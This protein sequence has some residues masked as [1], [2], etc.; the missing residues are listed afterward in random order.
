MQRGNY[1]SAAI[2]IGAGELGLTL[3]TLRISTSPSP[4]SPPLLLL[5]LLIGSFSLF[6]LLLPPSAETVPDS[7]WGS[8]VAS[9]FSPVQ[10]GISQ[11]TPVKLLSLKPPF[12]HRRHGAPERSRARR[13]ALMAPWFALGPSLCDARAPGGVASRVPSSL[14]RGDSLAVSLLMGK[15]E[16]ERSRRNLQPLLLL[17]ARLAARLGRPV[18][19]GV[20]VAV[21]GGGGPLDAL[22]LG[23]GG[24]LALGG[25]RGRG[26]FAG[27]GAVASRGAVAGRGARGGVGCIAQVGIGRGR[28][29]LRGGRG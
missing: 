8:G 28:G 10:R 4:A 21:H 9:L 15:G 27:R 24:R 29:G 16:V 13:P 26:A 7:S 12:C 2:G 20:A 3:A 18:A 1:D 14:R 11:T 19:A 6:S 22:L 17:G 25:L 5:S 23:A